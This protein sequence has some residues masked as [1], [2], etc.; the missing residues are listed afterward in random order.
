M[1]DFLEFS[2]LEGEFK[3]SYVRSSGSG[4]QNVN[5]VSTKAVLKWNVKESKSLPYFVKK[6]FLNKWSSRISMSGVI[7]LTSDKHRSQIRN[8]EEVLDRLKSMVEEV[9]IPQKKRIPKKPPRSS[10]EKRLR[11]KKL[12][13]E[14]KKNRKKFYDD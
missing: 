12:R 10:V 14:R 2:L 9:L 5:K 6:R 7:S 4:G 11:E 1:I 3:V 8:L 13:A